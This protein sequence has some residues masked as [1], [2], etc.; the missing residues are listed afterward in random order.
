MTDLHWDNGLHADSRWYVN[1]AIQG[2]GVTPTLLCQAGP[3]KLDEI[4][5]QHSD[6][7]SY[8]GIVDC[9]TTTVK[10]KTRHNPCKEPCSE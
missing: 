6:I 9:Y 7:R 2:L 10:D 5:S 4:D 1:Y 3:Y 8:A